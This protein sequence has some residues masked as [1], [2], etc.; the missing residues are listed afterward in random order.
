MGT[1]HEI[2][3]YGAIVVAAAVVVFVFLHDVP[4]LGRERRAE[5]AV[6]AF[7]D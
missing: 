7:G 6:A 3:L 5:T 1:L 4:L 2:F